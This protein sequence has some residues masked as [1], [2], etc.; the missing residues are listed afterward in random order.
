MHSRWKIKHSGIKLKFDKYVTKTKPRKNSPNT[1]FKLAAV[2]KFMEIGFEFERLLQV[3][4]ELPLERDDLLD[5]AEQRVDLGVRQ[6][7][8]LLQRFQIVLQQVVQVLAQ[9][10]D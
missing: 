5:V 10:R 2:F 7:R 1:H 4:Q 6:K 8:L 9:S 3:L